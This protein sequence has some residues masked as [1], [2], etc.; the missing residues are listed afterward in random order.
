MQ[1]LEDTIAKFE[2]RTGKS[3]RDHLGF[4]KAGTTQIKYLKDENG[5]YI[6][7]LKDKEKEV[8][9]EE[10][11]IKERHVEIAKKQLKVDR[12]N[13]QLADSAK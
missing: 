9:N 6:G 3:V 13:R 12:L 8:G 10:R 4:G 11:L 7:E 5:S 2:K 1:K